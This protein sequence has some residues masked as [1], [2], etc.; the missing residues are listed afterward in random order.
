MQVNKVAASRN[1][2]S[3]REMVD[4]FREDCLALPALKMKKG[5][6]YWTVTYGELRGYVRA[7]GASLVDLGV[8]HG[9]RVGLISENRSEWV[10]T[11]LAVTCAGAVIVPYDILLKTEELSSI[12]RA[13]GARI[14]FT[15]TEYRDKVSRACAGTGP[16]GTASGGCLVLFDDDTAGPVPPGWSADVFT[17]L[18]DKGRRLGAGGT[19]PAAALPVAPDDLAALIFTSGTTGTPKGVMLSHRNLVENADGVQMTTPLGPGDN[20]II[21]L[22]FHHTYPTSMGI[23]TP[24]LSY[25]M[26]TSVPSMKTNVLIGI[27]K[28]TGATCVPAMPLLIERIYK[29]VLANVKAKGP[30]VRVLFAVMKGISTF[31]FKV[32]HVRIGKLL[33]GS[34]ARE[35]GVQKLRFFVSGGGPIAKEVIDGME[36]LGLVT[37]QGYGL[38]ETSPVI[39]STCP[40]HNKP[41][42]VGLPLSNVEV[43]I[44]NPD[45]NGN[46]EILTRGSHVML[47]YYNMPE[48]TREVIDAD[49][50]LHTGDIGKLDKDGYLYITGRLKNIIVTKGG[51]NIYP[52]EIEN[53]LTASPLL[54]EVVVIGRQ[55]SE[56]G[57]YPHAIIYPDPE[58]LAGMQK[59]QNRT[60]SDEEVRGIVRAEIHKC[61]SG[62]AV[63]KIPRG[64]DVS[65]EELPKTSTRKVKRFMFT[66]VRE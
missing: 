22:P 20:W 63:Y 61:T 25:G 27:M 54:S 60:F 33:F 53:L 4:T 29:G 39:S 13:S 9:D 2:H 3:V 16:A 10:I 6:G 56:G 46:G 42:S 31:F 17:A 48:K 52:E 51:K 38:T 55:D 40:A 41:G 30:L 24:L 26:I 57:E 21:V 14:I 50:W 23:F 35:L 65:R 66:E 28:D 5:E 64:F 47:G 36:A 37:Y 43:R 34:V 12:V 44:D 18:V 45:Q 11:Y 15:S 59:E 7:L 1:V 8:R 58:I 32:L 19:D 62:A 49:G